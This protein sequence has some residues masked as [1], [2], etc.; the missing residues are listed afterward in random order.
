MLPP[1]RFTFLGTGTSVGIPMVGCTCSVCN[2][3]DPRNHRFRCAALIRLPRGNVLIDTPPE[4][5]LQLL[6][7]KVD[8]LHAVLFTHPHADH[9]HGLDDVRPICKYLNG[10]VPLFCNHEV[11]RKIR[12]TFSYAFMPDADKLP[13]GFIPRLTFQHIDD[14]PFTVL[15]ETVTPIPLIHAH[16]NVLGF[17]I[18]D[19]AYCTDVNKIPPESW[20]RLEGL[21]VLILDC[22]RHKPHPGHFCLVEALEVVERLRPK[23]A[24]FTHMSHDFEHEDTNRRLPDH[25]RLAHDGLTFE[26]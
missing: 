26:F 17:R 22:L 7:E 2:S 23:R 14:D 13:A 12:Q 5:R 25:V 9:L 16:F 19:L 1:A 4:L 8:L 20:P 21:D 15:G 6:R 3:S 18:R 24:F 10:P 11:E